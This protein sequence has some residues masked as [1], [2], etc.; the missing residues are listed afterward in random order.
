M[1]TENK[2]RYKITQRG[3]STQ[4]TSLLSLEFAIGRV[5]IFGV[6]RPFAKRRNI[7]FTDSESCMQSLHTSISIFFH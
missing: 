4:S 6:A 7:Y 3:Q 5:I 1:K 2:P